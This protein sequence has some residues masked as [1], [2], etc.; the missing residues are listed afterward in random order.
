MCGMLL[1][2][3][4]AKNKGNGEMKTKQIT[5]VYGAEDIY[6]YRLINTGMSSR[7]YGRCEVCE[8]YVSDVHIQTELVQV[9]DRDQ[10]FW[11][12]GKSIFGH[13]DCLVGARHDGKVTTEL[14]SLTLGRN[15]WI[16]DG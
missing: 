4:G 2:M 8:E 3:D 6:L 16:I 10:T 7:R 12:Q 5:K 1:F 13:E 15:T 14:K 9:V 11:S